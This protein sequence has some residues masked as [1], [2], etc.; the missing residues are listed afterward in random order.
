M[1]NKKVGRKCKCRTGSLIDFKASYWKVWPWRFNDIYGHT[2]YEIRP[3]KC[4]DNR[5]KKIIRFFKRTQGNFPKIFV[6]S[7]Q[8]KVIHF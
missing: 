6:R 1:N 2:Y 8:F 5:L 7:D 3:W 4:E